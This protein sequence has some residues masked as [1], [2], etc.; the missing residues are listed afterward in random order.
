[1]VEKLVESEEENQHLLSA[2]ECIINREHFPVSRIRHAGNYIPIFPSALP[3]LFLFLF[4]AWSAA[5]HSAYT[6][7]IT[8]FHHS[9][10]T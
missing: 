2:A 5:D 1:M 8:P 3:A 10:I 9:D 4:F 7:T 6:P